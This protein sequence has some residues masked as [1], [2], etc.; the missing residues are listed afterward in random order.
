MENEFNRSV[1]VK[2]YRLMRLSTKS[3]GFQSTTPEENTTFQS[4]Q[5]QC[6][7]N[8]SFLLDGSNKS[9]HHPVQSL[10]SHYASFYPE[11]TVPTVTD[12]M[13]LSSVNQFDTEQ[14]TIDKNLL[15]LSPPTVISI[16]HLDMYQKTN[17][18]FY[19]YRTGRVHRKSKCSRSNS[20][21]QWRFF[22]SWLFHWFKLSRLWIIAVR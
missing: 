1:P 14:Q 8:H 19:S 3:F 17:K 22:S 9:P 13:E 11:M 5:I 21:T 2:S 10:T 7:N 20:T 15:K 12:P 18:I 4:T 6:K 16:N